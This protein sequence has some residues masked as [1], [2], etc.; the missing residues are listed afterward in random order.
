VEA[1]PPVRCAQRRGG[2]L[3]RFWNGGGCGGKIL[4]HVQ[5]GH[6]RTGR[7]LGRGGSAQH[8]NRHN[9]P[10]VVKARRCVVRDLVFLD[11]GDGTATD[12]R[13]RCG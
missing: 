10:T 3:Q 5:A 6:T 11:F 12:R 4:D 9:S 13:S 1:A 7:G 2:R 8:E